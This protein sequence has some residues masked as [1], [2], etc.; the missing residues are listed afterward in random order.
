VQHL[1]FPFQ[2][3]SILERLRRWALWPEINITDIYVVMGS[4]S[5]ANRQS[6]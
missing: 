3:G 5:M 2:D 6:E 4:V 1:I